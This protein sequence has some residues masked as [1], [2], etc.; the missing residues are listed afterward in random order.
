VHGGRAIAGFGDDRHVRLAV[1]Q[2]LQPMTNGYVIVGKK[3][4]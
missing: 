4:P 2:Q 3:N 1:D